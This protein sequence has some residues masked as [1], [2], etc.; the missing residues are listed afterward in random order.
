MSII[1]RRKFA[2]NIITTA[3]AVVLAPTFGFTYWKK[4]KTPKS[5]EVVGHGDYQYRVHKHWGVQDEAKIPVNDCHEMVMDSKGHLILLTNE[6]KNNV[7]VYDRSGKVLRTWGNQ[8]P[9]GHG[10]TLANEGG[11]EFLFITDPELHQVFKCTL[12]GRILM[13]LDHPKEIKAYENADQYKPTEVAVAP[14]G[15]FYVADGY[16]LDY[17][18]Q[19]S[20]GG[21][22]IR[23]FGGKGEGQ[24]ELMNAHG[25]TF[26][27]RSYDNPS[28][29]VTSRARQ[30]LKRFSL[31]GEHLET[32]PL[33]GCWI[34]RP[35]VDDENIYFA[36]IVSKTWDTYDGF[37]A[38]LNKDNQVVSAPGGSKPEY[39]HGDLQA[40][41]YDGHTF[42]NP[43]DVCVDSDKNLY[44]PQWN[45]G[46]TYPVV[47]ERI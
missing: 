39:N 38:V 46:R 33:P 28:L 26:D 13:T 27:T 20:P 24:A 37:V 21:E 22:Y 10:L 15:D 6:T 3:A 41:A 8:F 35:V 16:G 17:I 47:L 25:V 30:E 4:M 43:H 12:D 9:G 18:I 45:S 42:M 40:I 29:L 7:I 5:A 19:Y 23:H 31:S 1:T 11:E 14:N 44:I 36:V 2:T 34:C 32:I